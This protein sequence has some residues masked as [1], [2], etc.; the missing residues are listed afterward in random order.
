MRL[1]GVSDLPYSPYCAY[2]SIFSIQIQGVEP[3]V[4]QGW[5]HLVGWLHD[6]GIP[7]MTV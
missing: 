6:H 1:L 5:T 3:A 2:A 7:Y 4:A